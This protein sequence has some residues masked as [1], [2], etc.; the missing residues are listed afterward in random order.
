MASR[1]DPPRFFVAVFFWVF[2]ADFSVFLAFGAGFGR[3]AFRVGLRTL[4]FFGR[5]ALAAAGRR[6]G[7]D[8][9]LTARLAAFFL[10]A[11]AFR[12]GFLAIVRLR[13]V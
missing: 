12:T 2:L 9:L 10:P 8:A 1:P 13:S 4:T 6:F 11:F 5:L 3:E 7:A